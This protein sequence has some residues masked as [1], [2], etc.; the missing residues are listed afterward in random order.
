MC[1]YLTKSNMF[2]C[3]CVFSNILT[4]IEFVCV[5]AITWLASVCVIVSRP[6][7]RS[8]QIGEFEPVSG[9]ETI[10]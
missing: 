7:S 4:Y 5:M 3:Q 1:Y 9:C 10:C 2:G 6:R 8:D